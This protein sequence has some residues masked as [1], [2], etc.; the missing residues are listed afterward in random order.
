[1]PESEC[2]D[3]LGKVLD[4]LKEYT[5][6]VDYHSMDVHNCRMHGVEKDCAEASKD[7][8]KMMELENELSNVLSAI[9]KHCISDPPREYL[10]YGLTEEEKANPEL[11]RKL[12]SCI[13]DVEKK[14]CPESA[15][16][17]DGKFDYSKCD[18]N[19]VA[20]CRASIERSIESLV[21]K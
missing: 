4:L 20:V 11:L 5:K 17:P 10:P 9:E 14:S 21:E 3:F 15:V 7:L 1:M 18:V 2:A 8:S 6:A 19:P 16:G 13:R 12:S